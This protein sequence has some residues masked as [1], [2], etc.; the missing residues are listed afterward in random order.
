MIKIGDRVSVRQLTT[1]TKDIWGTKG[2][3]TKVRE[4]VMPTDYFQQRRWTPEPNKYFVEFDEP[5]KSIGAMMTG[6]WL[7]EAALIREL[8]N[9]G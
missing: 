6:I 2:T 7:V 3:I 4:D 9:V 1:I 5:T 8:E